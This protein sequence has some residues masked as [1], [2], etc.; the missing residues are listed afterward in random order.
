MYPTTYYTH[1]SQ[2][3]VS[4]DGNNWAKRSAANDVIFARHKTDQS[5]ETFTVMGGVTEIHSLPVKFAHVLE[6]YRKRLESLSTSQMTSFKR[7]A[8]AIVIQF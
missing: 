4:R 2:E 6:I 3:P 8:C 5:H 7:I 1:V